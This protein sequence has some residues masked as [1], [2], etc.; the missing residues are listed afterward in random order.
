V[1]SIGGVPDF[2]IRCDLCGVALEATKVV[3]TEQ[4]ATPVAQDRSGYEDQCEPMSTDRARVRKL[5]LISEACPLN[6]LAIE[7]VI[8]DNSSV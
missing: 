2:E 8:R 3:L 4:T 6:R 7:V 1:L 5:S